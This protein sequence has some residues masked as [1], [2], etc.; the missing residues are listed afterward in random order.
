MTANPEVTPFG[1]GFQFL[2]GELDH[3]KV[4]IGDNSLGT[5]KIGRAGAGNVHWAVCNL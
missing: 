2:G 3:S 4:R 1:Q 5:H